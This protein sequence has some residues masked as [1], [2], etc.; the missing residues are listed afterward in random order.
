MKEKYYYLRKSKADG[1]HKCGIIYLISGD[2]KTARGISLCNDT[3]DPFIRDDGFLP[4]KNKSFSPFMGGLKLAKKRA[5]KAFNST[6]S[7]EIIRRPEAIEKVGG[8]H[9]RFKSEYS[10]KLSAF[11]RKMLYGIGGVL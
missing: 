4:N 5:L 1:L 9:M 6:K 3:E 10:P 11:E 8:L 2:N 7:S